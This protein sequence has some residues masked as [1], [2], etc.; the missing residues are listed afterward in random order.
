MA[1]TDNVAAVSFDQRL[2]DERSEVTVLGRRPGGS[3]STGR[4]APRSPS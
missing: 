2:G 4:A 3:G 1:H